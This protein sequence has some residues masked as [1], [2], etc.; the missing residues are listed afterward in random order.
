VPDWVLWIIAAALLAA[1]EVAT[2]AFFLGPVALAALLAAL[3]A[4]VGVGIELQ[5]AAFAL[6]SIASLV[7]IRPIAK[8]HL[9]QPSHLRTGTAAL[10]GERAVTLER[11]DSGGGTVKLSGEVWSARP[12]DED[13]VIEPGTRVE[14]LSI[15]GATAFVSE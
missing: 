2:T 9:S 11:I 14:V 6:A 5:V 15:R 10:I 12:Y 3:L 7:V 13:A 8:R 1:G 4:A